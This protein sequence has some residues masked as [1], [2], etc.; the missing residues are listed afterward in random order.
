MAEAWRRCWAAASLDCS[1]SSSPGLG[2]Q[3]Y[4]DPEAPVTITS[5]LG[6]GL[7]TAA[8]SKQMPSVPPRLHGAACKQAS[9]SLRDR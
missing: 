6:C 2:R 4:M 8:A 1:S 3:A 9:R 7:F 5:S